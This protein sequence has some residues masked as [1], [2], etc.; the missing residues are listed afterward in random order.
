VSRVRTGTK[1][2]AQ[3]PKKP[4]Q[5]LKNQTISQLAQTLLN[6]YACLSINL[7]G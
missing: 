3:N 4:Q 2:P 1:E 7:E 6:G 5:I